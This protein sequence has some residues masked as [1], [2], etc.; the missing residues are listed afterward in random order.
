MFISRNLTWVLLIL[1]VV[2]SGACD[3]NQPVTIGGQKSS[4]VFGAQPSPSATPTPAASPS[5]AAA[6]SAAGSST[7]TSN[8]ILAER[9]ASAAEPCTTLEA[10]APRG[11]AC[12]H[13]MKNE[14]GVQSDVIVE[15][16]RRSCLQN[17]A[18]NYLVDGTFDYN[19]QRLER[20]IAALTTGGRN[21]LIE[22]Y[23]TNGPGQRRYPNTVASAFASNL[24][25]EEF[26]SRIKY[27][28]AFQSEYQ[29][30]VRSFLPVITYARA[31]G[32][33]VLIVPG[34]E[35]NYDDATFMQIY[36]LTKNALPDSL[37]LYYGRSPCPGCHDGNEGGI[38]QGVHA[39]DHR[40]T[41]GF[42]LSH[43][44]V[45]NDGSDYRIDGD[46]SSGRIPLDNLRAVRDQ[47]ARQSD[48]FILWSGRRQGL[49][50][51]NG[52]LV[53]IAPST[54]NYLIPDDAE[55]NEIIAF[56]R[57]Y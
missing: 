19:E 35:D 25:V 14:A 31:R 51:I 37:G 3:P 56:L 26:R 50:L 40:Q 8:V 55:Q 47:A 45:T 57:G 7:G 36:Q 53:S 18:I 17:V 30:H 27:D 29:Q 43:G 46:T 23:L 2:G 10:N 9:A 16:I 5:P 6:A 54:R 48:V 4:F 24:S 13:C 32:A 12:L 1:V 28:V 44:L 11:L 22:L 20:H 49:P 15:L 21:V 39:E 42:S 34:L 52:Q 38:P 33:Q 41:A